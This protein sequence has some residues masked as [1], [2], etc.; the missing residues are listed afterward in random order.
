MQRSFDRLKSDASIEKLQVG[1]VPINVQTVQNEN[2]NLP[3]GENRF[4]SN[5]SRMVRLNAVKERDLMEKQQ[6]VQQEKER[7]KNLK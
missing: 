5:T 7:R 2:Q 4:A 1:Q 3:Q 6:R